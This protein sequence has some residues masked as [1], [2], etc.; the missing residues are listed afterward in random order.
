MALAEE[1]PWSTS[2]QDTAKT[3]KSAAA[4]CD[5]VEVLDFWVGRCPSF[6][7][8]EMPSS[9]RIYMVYD[10]REDNWRHCPLAMT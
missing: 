5:P 1:K 2:M 8:K 7:P 6:P 4:D 10:I 9:V 3:M